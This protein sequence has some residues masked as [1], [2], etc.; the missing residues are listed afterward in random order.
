MR[1]DYHR[2]FSPRLGYDMELLIFGHAGLPVLVFPTSFGRFWDWE[3]RGLVRVLSGTIEAGNI[4]LCCVDSVDVESWYNRGAHPRHRVDRYVAYESYVVNEVVPL[5]QSDLP[6]GAD[7][8]VAATGCSLGAFHAALLAFRQPFA[9]SRM[10]S[11][12][13]KFENSGF[14]NGYSDQETYFTNPLAFLPGLTDPH[15]LGALRAMDIVLVTGSADPHVDEDY[16]LSRILWNKGIPHT[17]DVWDGWCH[18]WP[19][20]E[21]MVPKFL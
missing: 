8:R 1:R 7:R 5:L 19:Y 9:V 17:L 3:D 18:D 10:I 6:P 12:S 11:L 21:A 2:W 20:W 13:G 4:R 16:Q 14:L 15:T